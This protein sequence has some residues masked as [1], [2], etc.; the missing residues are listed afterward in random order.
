MNF[1][2]QSLTYLFIVIAVIIVAI[3]L[4]S[5]NRWVKELA[6]EERIKLEIW[7]LATEQMA[8][9]EGGSDMSLILKVLQSNN[10]IPII[11]YDEVSQAKI[12]HNIRLPL[13][14]EEEFLQKKMEEF[15]KRNPPIL[16]SEVN[17]WVYY[18]DSHTLKKL[19][20][21]PY[22]QFG[23]IAVFIALVFISLLNSQKAEQNKIL[24][25]LAKE[26]AHQLGTPISSLVAWTEYLRLK[27]LDESLL[28]EIDKD[29]NRLQTI[30]LRF[31]KIGSVSDKKEVH[32][33]QVIR[34]AVEYLEKRI[35][36]RVQIRYFFPENPILVSL[37][38]PL[39]H[40][41]IE[42]LTKNAVDA[43]DGQGSVVFRITEQKNNVILDIID[44][45]KGIPK[46]KFKSVFQAGY[47]TK[48]RGWGLGL[49]LVKRIVE[50]YHG[51]KIFVKQS[52]P[53]KGTTFR[54]L[55]KMN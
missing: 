48:E 13:E 45:G 40:W 18:D 55:L 51:G 3:S 34:T 26:T 17:Q 8:V 6:R 46:S 53:G 33:Q 31:S 49:S 2:K 11:L 41:V 42:N 19:Q 15:G 54:I 9:G 21:Y 14:N 22:V 37:N 28:S 47:T 12:S 7:S 36:N 44:T 1:S 20:L 25:G 5:S 4:I 35:S 38:E 23:I 29:V 52:E 27:A 32:L 16:L 39:I 30:A 50:E 10:S 24:V 43:M